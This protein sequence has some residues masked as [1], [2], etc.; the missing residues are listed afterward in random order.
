MSTLAS[1]P[2]LR[3]LTYNIHKASR[4]FAGNSLS[5]RVRRGLDLR[6]QAGIPNRTVETRISDLIQRVNPHVAG[7][8]E[9]RN[10]N[11]L[12][13]IRPADYRSYFG[14][15]NWK[16]GNGLLLH[17]SMEHQR[18]YRN[19][20]IGHQRWVLSV[21]F[22][23]KETTVTAYTTHLEPGADRFEKN[24]GELKRIL[25]ATPNPYLI[26]GDFNPRLDISTRRRFEFER[27]LALTAAT[28]GFTNNTWNPTQNIDNAF[29][30][31]HFE[32]GHVE[33]GADNMSDHAY[34]T[35]DAHLIATTH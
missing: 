33:I 30:T 7:L 35:G 10:D 11:Q 23:F 34:V 32:I 1:A 18:N 19:L 20:N 31:S 13:R 22:E 28:T 21:D 27:D 14:R 2:P 6:F 12:K 16:Q 4:M 3:W 29:F 24:Y 9:V 25:E 8:Q 26:L 15:T 17:G 5:E